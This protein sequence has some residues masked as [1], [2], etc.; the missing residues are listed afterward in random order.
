MSQEKKPPAGEEFTLLDGATSSPIDLTEE[1][2]SQHLVASD[3]ERPLADRLAAFEDVYEARWGTP[4]SSG[5]ATSSGR[6]A[7]ARSS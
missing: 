1:Y 3:L 6:R 5:R 2:G 4:P 7:C